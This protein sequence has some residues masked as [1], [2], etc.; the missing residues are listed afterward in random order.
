MN[1]VEVKIFRFIYNNILYTTSDPSM[2]LADTCSAIG[3][4]VGVPVTFVVAFSLGVL[5]ASLLC[6]ILRRTSYKPSH[7]DP[8]TVYE[9]VG[10]NMKSKDNIIVMD[11][12]TAYG[13]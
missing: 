7:D 3:T 2:L 13:L 6:Y 9:E 10:N 12:N 11:T 1:S 8:A 5:V 4:A